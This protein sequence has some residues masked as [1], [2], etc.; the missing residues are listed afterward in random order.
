[1]ELNNYVF[2]SAQPADSYFVWQVEVQIV[3]F[4]KHDVSQYMH[5]TVWF[6]DH[7]LQPWVKLA[8]KYPEV[9]FFFY[10][11][12]GVQLDLYISQLRPHILKRHF[13][14]HPELTDKV[15]FYHDS[16]IIFNFL[17][18]FGDLG[19]GPINWVSDTSG[20]LDYKY[21]TDKEK[22]GKIPHEEA[23][24]KMAE[25]GGVTVDHFKQYIGRTGGAQYILKGIDGDFWQDV[26]NQCLEIRR[27]FTFGQPGSF[28][29]KY[30]HTES[31]GFQSWCADM[32]AVNM[33][34]WSRGKEYDTTKELDFSWATDTAERYHA[35]PIMHNAGA[36]GTQPGVFF[37]GQYIHT[38]PIGKKF[39]V[40]KDTASYYYVK[41]IEEVK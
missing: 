10:K 34:L 35:K 9:R 30:F 24:K 19:Q 12:E 23:V 38:S 25:I 11:D 20:Y 26:E 37:K 6:K 4:R 28:N 40:R 13:W 41:A 27:A 22:E 36:T 3:N 2:L 15:I 5:V 18:V 32:W 7:D 8:E 21:L 14:N 1:M 16:D 33:A 17:P 39:A 29:T 31:A